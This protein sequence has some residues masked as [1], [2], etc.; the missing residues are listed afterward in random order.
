[1]RVLQRLSSLKSRLT[2][3]SSQQAIEGI[4]DLLAILKAG[5]PDPNVPHAKERL[6]IVVTE[7]L[8]TCRLSTEYEDLSGTIPLREH[9]QA[10]Q[11]NP[12]EPQTRQS[13]VLF[14]L[15]SLNLEEIIRLTGVDGDPF[16]SRINQLR[17]NTLL[18]DSSRV[19]A[20]LNSLY[21]QRTHTLTF[22]ANSKY[23]HMFISDDQHQVQTHLEERSKGFQWFFSFCMTLI[24]ESKGNPTS[25]LLLLDEPGIH[26]HPTAQRELVQFLHH[27]GATHTVLYTTHSPFMLDETS[28]DGVWTAYVDSKGHSAVQEGLPADANLDL[29]PPRA[30]AGY[31]IVSWMIARGPTL[32]VE[33]KADALY[34]H[35]LQKWCVKKG[36]ESLP[37]QIHIVAYGGTRNAAA[38]VA[39]FVSE[40]IW[41]VVLLDGDD[42]GVRKAQSLKDT[43][44]LAHKDGVL[45]LND[46]INLAD[47]EIEDLIGLSE[48]GPVIEEITGGTVTSADLANQSG[49]VVNRVK[50]ASA[51][52]SFQL[53]AEKGGRCPIAAAED[54]DG[55]AG[56]LDGGLGVA[57]GHGLDLS[58]SVL[59][60]QRHGTAD[61][62]GGRR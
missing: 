6:D 39:V 54:L 25:T 7:S 59:R 2:P 61:N 36:I 17:L 13:N 15:A 12:H 5:A 37:D 42:A 57:V 33:G 26:L 56:D 18:A 19:T 24:A 11:Q 29:F 1:M 60:F 49:S 41:P 21:E 35:H 45:C 38:T 30:A 47:C 31:K 8:P 34:L 20:E 23:F 51:Q 48:V 22:D 55:E 14:E 3:D 52:K 28:L 40:E 32:L 27:L 10:L 53:P 43:F 9:Y 46:H 16:N 50:D 58:T 44:Y 4:D 62:G